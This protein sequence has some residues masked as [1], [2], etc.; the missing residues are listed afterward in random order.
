MIGFAL[1]L[2]PKTQASG[3]APPPP[4]QPSLDFTDSRNSGLCALITGIA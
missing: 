4:Y 1:S 2:W 3:S